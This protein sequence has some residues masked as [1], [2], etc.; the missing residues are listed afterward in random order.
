M[1]AAHEDQLLLLDLQRLDQQESRL[2]HQRDSH[3]AHATLAEL[4][5]RADDLRRATVTQG[6]VISDIGREAERLAGEIDKVRARRTLQQGRLERG[7]V[8]LRDMSAMEREIA[9]M[10]QR[11][12]DLEDAQ[13][14]AEE[15]LEAA[16][17]ARR[18][19]SEEGE[20]I[21]ADVRATQERFT[22]DMGGVDDDL[23]RVLKDRAD[24]AARLPGDLLAEYERSRTRNGALAVIEIR[25]GL[26][27]GAATDL[28]PAELGAIA[29]LAPDEL[30][31]AE[32]TG[33]LVVRTGGAA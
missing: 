24:L 25:G 27:L 33:Q 3:P 12:S 28:A 4:S 8:P 13:L 11:I 23:R 20:A 18:A 22:Q 15:R 9:R 7:E 26:A 14:D 16:E 5:G 2:R 21:A 32:E 1:K 10:D 29:A 30:Y 6:A 31:W 19:M 17:A